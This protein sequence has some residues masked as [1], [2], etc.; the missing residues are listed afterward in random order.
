MFASTS[1]SSTSPLATPS[2]TPP[3]LLSIEEYLHTTYHPD[4]D[5]VDGI[6][7]QRN[8]GEFEH[9]TLQIAIGS[10]FFTHR[11]EWNIRVITELRTRVSPTR[12]RIPDVCVVPHEGPL[13][14]V[15]VT[16]P[17]L[18][19]EILSPEDRLSRTIRV[20]DDYLNMGVLN[21]WVI[22]PIERTAFVYTRDGLRLV[23]TPRLT[24]ENSPIYLDLPELFSALD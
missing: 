4:C 13:E 5:F 3:A 22:D 15:R 19:I 8:L 23:D 10:W 7:E 9:G 17:I 6:L 16:P 12:I 18:C 1:S 21:L 20:L 2:N 11:A 24:I 14:K